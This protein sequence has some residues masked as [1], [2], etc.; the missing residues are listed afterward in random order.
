MKTPSYLSKTK[1]MAGMQCPKNLFLQVY[2]KKLAAPITAA[3]Q[4][5]F[6]QGNLVGEL[7]QKEFKKDTA[8]VNTAYWDFK[9]ALTKTEEF[10]LQGKKNIFEASFSYKGIF[11]RVDILEKVQSSDGQDVWNLVEVKSGTK[12]KDENVKDVALQLWIL[13]NLGY[14]VQSCYLMHINNQCVFPDMSNFFHKQDI[15][16]RAQELKDSVANSIIEL[17]QMVDSQQEPEVDIGPHCNAPYECKFKAHCGKHLPKDS[18]FLLPSME[19]YDFK[20]EAWKKKLWGFYKKNIIEIKDI[21]EGEL[22]AKQQI[23]K[24]VHVQDQSYIHR[25]G[26]AADLKRWQWPLQ[27]LSF[28]SINP[29]VPFWEGVRPYEQIPFQYTVGLGQG[30]GQDLGQGLSQGLGQGKVVYK[31]YLHN[32]SKDPRLALAEQL[33]EDLKGEG[34]IA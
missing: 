25:Q 8:L 20:E 28:N 33:V 2:N 16:A 26:I 19:E 5:I 23:A 34:S 6:D 7:A 3:E 12:V 1:M 15:T 9:G 17:K 22:N 11:A 27:Y 24:K 29:A 4:M 32:D 21:P 10:I 14:K 30:L 18:I 13:E 31:N